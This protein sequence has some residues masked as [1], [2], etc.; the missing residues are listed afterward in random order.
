MSSGIEHE[1][2]QGALINALGFVGKTA[3]PL[4]FVLVTRL[5]G[6][7]IL[8]IYITATAL[9]ETAL[10]FLVG[11][12]KDGALI[13]VARH[14]DDEN[15]HPQ[16]YMA[17]ANTLGW[18]LL[19]ALCV[20]TAILA[21]GDPVIP[22]LYTSFGDR[23]LPMLK[24]MAFVLP[25]MAFERV[26]LGATQGLKIMKYEAFLGGTIRP[27][28]LVIISSAFWLEWPTVYGLAGAYVATQVLIFLIAVWIYNRELSW[29]ELRHAARTF[30]LNREVLSF[31]L[32]QNLN[33][34]FDRFLT[35]IDV[36]MLGSFGFSAFDIGFYGAGALIARELR[37]VKLIFSS[38]FSP[39]VVRLFK[40]RNLNGLADSLATTARWITIPLI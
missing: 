15:E 6:P 12:F 21:F 36:I 31:A 26:V 32:P 19:L 4:F 13:F 40:E 2:R 37:Q 17:L 8:G 38:A 11:G 14:A 27:I 3:G 28:L 33:A 1:V 23:L 5:Y 18:S 22:R 9:V 25:L 10:A 35:N 16:L 24:L 20:G 30:R 29:I 39:H 7:E 34:T